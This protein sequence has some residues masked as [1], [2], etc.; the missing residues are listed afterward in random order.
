[1]KSFVI[2]SESTLVV[3]GN[4]DTNLRLKHSLEKHFLYLLIQ[5]YYCTTS[6]STE[7]F[8]THLQIDTTRRHTLYANM[9]F[10]Q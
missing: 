9:C 4:F 6:F 2:E 7:T 8:D 10:R 5:Q 1:M 3:V